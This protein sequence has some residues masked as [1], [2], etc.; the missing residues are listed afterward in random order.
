M[1]NIRI[2]P[3]NVANQ[4]AAGEVVERPASVIRELL[5]NSIDAGADRIGIRIESGGK[6]LIRVT[7]NGVGMDR[8]DMLLSMERHSTSKIRDISDIFSIK[9]L[10]FRGEALPSICSV[11]RLEILSRLKDQTIGHRL[12][13]SGGKLISIDETGAA[14]GTSISVRDIFFNTPAR[15][16]F[17]KGDKT[18]TSYIT[19]TVSRIALPF[20]HI[21]IKLDD[22]EKTILN[23]PASEDEVNRFSAL[24]GRT[25]A[26]SLIDVTDNMDG[27]S[28]RVF[29]A[30][31]DNSRNRADRVFIYINRRGI[32][33]KLVTR[34]I[35]DGYGQRL[36]KGRYPQVIVFITIDPSLVDVNVHPA[37]QEVR[38][39]EGNRIYQTVSRMIDRALRSQFKPFFD[40]GYPEEKA[41]FRT[42]EGQGAVSEQTWTYR[43]SEERAASPVAPSVTASSPSSN[44][45]EASLFER[46]EAIPRPV[47]KAGPTLIGQLK[48]T[49][50]LFQSEEGLLI[51]D[52]H[53]A[54]ER[55]LYER[56]KKNYKEMKI[57]VQPFLIPVRI[58]TSHKDQRVLME[59]IDQLTGMGFELEPFGGNT[60]LLR[61]V[62]SIL[63]DINW[64]RFMSDLIP[65]LQRDGALTIDQ[66]ID[67]LI[68][69]MACHGAIKAGQTLSQREMINLLEELDRLNLPTNCP[70]G[71]P[72]FKRFSYY[73][74]ERMFKRIV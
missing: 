68:T 60:F 71:R 39:Q 28:V 40:T 11:S 2:L 18:E 7:D 12:T 72:V 1:S 66:T 37:K 53:A 69:L 22:S 3:E 56:L 25:T 27:C 35:M 38:F 48:D 47:I 34:S 13:A 33:D 10:G 9:T 8:D 23:I 6:R 41:A 49:Y 31:P 62:P 26:S 30:P 21:H 61:A 5:D 57:D 36:M 19:D 55:I 70:H 65:V 42:W 50:L 44:E 74:I 32:R 64:E 73:D 24:L 63:T 17:L 52:Q 58:E 54:H 4:I 59:G 15:L 16:K 45:K 46:H 43:N 67:E 20:N 29:L 14:P 51:M